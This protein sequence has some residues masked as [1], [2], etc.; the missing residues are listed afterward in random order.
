MDAVK[1]MQD[2]APSFDD[3]RALRVRR[4]MRLATRGRSP[5]SKIIAGAINEVYEKTAGDLLESTLDKA[6]KL[7]LTA[8]GQEDEVATYLRLLACEA[9]QRG[10][11]R[12]TA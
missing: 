11:G 4:V 8:E 10:E 5:S 3:S 12:R 1:W 7:G 6:R 9:W 2:Q